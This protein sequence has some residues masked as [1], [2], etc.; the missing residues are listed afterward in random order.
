MQEDGIS[1]LQKVN[2]MS[3]QFKQSQTDHNHIQH[4]VD[5][6]KKYRNAN[7]FLKTFEK[8]P[9]E[10]H[11][12]NECHANRMSEQ[13]GRKR[14][15]DDVCS[16]VGGRQGDSDDEVRRHEAQQYKDK[17]LPLPARQEML[18]HRNRAFTVRALLSN[19]I[20]NR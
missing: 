16:G 9:G 3:K 15:L 6:D 7:R 19:S 1:P 11:Y 10:K 18:K 17:Q 12:Q 13:A 14:V 2:W 8:D 5:G 4:Q 20:V